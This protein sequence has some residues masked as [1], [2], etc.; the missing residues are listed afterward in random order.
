MEKE[1]KLNKIPE[2][3]ILGPS[4][5]YGNTLKEQKNWILQL[6]KVEIE[7]I[8]NAILATKS[9]KIKEIN[10]SNFPLPLLSL[11]LS[12]IFNELLNGRGFVLLRG[13]PINDLSIEEIARAY[14]GIGKYIGS[15]RSQN[16]NG[17]LLG[18]VID[19]SRSADDPNARIYQTS[20][21]QNYHCDSTDIVGLLCLQKAM[22][23]GASSIV[24]SVTI[25]NEILKNAPEH[26]K[27]LSSVFYIDRRGEVPKGKK[28]W[29]K[30][31]VFCWY[32][33][34]FW[35]FLYWDCIQSR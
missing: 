3:E 17:D 28:P 10:K 13:L 23:G 15:P 34:F 9:L 29:Y 16:A 11:K 27:E 21:R 24:S 25:F 22:S 26:I 35:F 31:P 14:W 6:S 19:L 8:T 20:A 18:H 5:W 2:K 33:N 12:N 4:A 30:L 32:D 1:Y 7:E